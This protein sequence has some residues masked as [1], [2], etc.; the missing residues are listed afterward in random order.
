[1]SGF[2][3]AKAIKARLEA[4]AGTGGL[5][6]VGTPL[7]TG[8]YY[9]NGTLGAANF[10]Y[11]VITTDSNKSSHMGGDGWMVNW[12][13]TVYDA[14]GNGEGTLW[15]V[16]RRL[17][18][19]GTSG[20]SYGLFKHV[21]VLDTDGTLNPQGFVASDMTVLTESFGAVENDPNCIALAM[22]GTVQISTP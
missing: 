15:P 10:A 12:T 2:L 1:M 5:F 19:P 20:P 22:T 21:L 11:A 4:D 6:N 18:G 8:C 17:N 16:A 7:L 3:V 13:I 14:A 9:T